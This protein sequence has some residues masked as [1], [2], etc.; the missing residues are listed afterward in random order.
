MS[1]ATAPETVIPHVDDLHAVSFDRLESYV[2]AH[3]DDI[4]E[5]YLKEQSNAQA[6]PAVQD[7]E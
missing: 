7:S 1:K 2:L 3:L 6:E 4:N 5:E